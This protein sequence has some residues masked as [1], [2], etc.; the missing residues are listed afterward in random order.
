[1][2]CLARRLRVAQIENVLGKGSWLGVGQRQLNPRKAPVVLLDDKLLE[3]V[4]VE[5]D[6][7]SALLCLGMILWIKRSGPH[8][9]AASVKSVIGKIY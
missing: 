9:A 3:R 6:E 7:E 5:V 4:L 8:L 1:M 2:L